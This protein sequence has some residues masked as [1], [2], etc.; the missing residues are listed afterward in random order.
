MAVERVRGPLLSKEAPCAMICS[1][2]T[3]VVAERNT[4]GNIKDRKIK[5]CRV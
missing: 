5:V 2:V 1:V 3:L 4:R